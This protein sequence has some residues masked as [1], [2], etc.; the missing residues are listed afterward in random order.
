MQGCP[1]N[2]VNATSVWITCGVSAGRHVR[3]VPSASLHARADKV[4]GNLHLCSGLIFSVKPRRGRVEGVARMAQF[5]PLQ[6]GNAVKD[7]ISAPRLAY[8]A[9]LKL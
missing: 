2:I 3:L 7:A 9:V 5:A 6:V 4:H 1:V 8:S